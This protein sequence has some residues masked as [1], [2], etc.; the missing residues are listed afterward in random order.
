[1]EPET[2]EESR[3]MQREMVEEARQTKQE[4]EAKQ[5]EALEEIQQGESL[6]RYATVTMGNLDLEVKAWL[7]GEVEDTVLQA[8]QLGESKDP[9][10]IKRSMETMLSA[11]SEMTT[12]DT[13][14]MGFWRAYY[15][16]WGAEGMIQAVETV[17]E[18]ASEH[19]EAKQDSLQS[20]RKEQSRDGF[21]DGV[22]HDERPT[23]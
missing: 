1:M 20:F 2:L 11:L 7:P 16:K 9:A 18:P 12:S 13:Y 17:L 5:R 14:N 8:Q 21:R 10:Q 4:L 6:E 3:E 15:H 22:R 23:E 19:L